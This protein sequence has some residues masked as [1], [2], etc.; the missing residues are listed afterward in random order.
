MK[1]IVKSLV[2]NRPIE[3][4]YDV[5]TCQRRC[6]VWQSGIVNAEKVTEGPAGVGSEYEHM[7]SFLGFRATNR[8]R[9]TVWDPPYRFAVHSDGSASSYD[10]E[11]S[12]EEVEGG[13]RMTST[14][15]MEGANAMLSR[16]TEPL[17]RMGLERMTER[18][19]NTLK[20][21][22]ENESPI[23]ADSVVI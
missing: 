23:L 19:L 11:M 7:S 13:T 9:I 18:D 15:T 10:V 20:E 2:I 3:E 14:F 21:L 5:A 8:P 1:P 17:V 4:V 16:F 12:F 22:M 6:V